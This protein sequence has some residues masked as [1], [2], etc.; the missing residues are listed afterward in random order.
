MNHITVVAHGAPGSFVRNVQTNPQIAV[1]LLNAVKAAVATIPDP[2]NPLRVRLQA[3]VDLA[4][5][6]HLPRRPSLPSVD[7]KIVRSEARA[8]ALEQ[9]R[10][11]AL[12]G[13]H[14]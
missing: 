8:I 11:E 10:P 12:R 6:G 3:A 7:P 13:M 4:E 2:L 1:D 14:L 9:D 5:Q